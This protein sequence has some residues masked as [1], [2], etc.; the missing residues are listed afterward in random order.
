MVPCGASP[1]AMGT[2]TALPPSW[3][4]RR[5]RSPHPDFDRIVS[6]LVCPFFVHAEFRA[7]HTTSVRDLEEYIA[8]LGLRLAARLHG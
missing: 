4:N 7:R 6:D 8:D 3:K 1:T 2:R 5:A